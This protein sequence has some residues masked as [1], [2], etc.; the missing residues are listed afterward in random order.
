[1]A[2]THGTFLIDTGLVDALHLPKVKHVALLAA[3]AA[4]S[5]RVRAVFAAS[6]LA[7]Q[8]VT[9]ARDSVKGVALHAPVAAV[10]SREGALLTEVK[11]AGIALAH[12]QQLIE[13]KANFAFIAAPNARL[14]AYSAVLKATGS[15]L[16][17]IRIT[18]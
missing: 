14:V 17:C 9:E 3:I 4:M 16:T 11:E 10:W 2:L 12:A 13:V 15:I 18:V 5:A 6:D 1:M 7:A 8:V